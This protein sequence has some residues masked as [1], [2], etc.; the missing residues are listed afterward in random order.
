M[1]TGLKLPSHE[2]IL[3]PLNRNLASIMPSCAS[4]FEI[5]LRAALALKGVSN[6]LPQLGINEAKF[7]LRGY[8]IHSWPGNC[9]PVGMK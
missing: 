9:S 2:C 8:N 1:P 4:W 7:L 6:Q 5:R 3:Y